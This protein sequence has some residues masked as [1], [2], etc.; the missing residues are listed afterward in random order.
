[1][2]MGREEN[3]FSNENILEIVVTFFLAAVI[4]GLMIKVVF[5]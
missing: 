3:K 4:I 1:M 2:K 5:F